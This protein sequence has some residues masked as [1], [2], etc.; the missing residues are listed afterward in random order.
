[1]PVPSW[2]MD[3][4][5]HSRSERICTNSLGLP[6]TQPQACVMNGPLLGISVS[7]GTAWPLKGCESKPSL[8]PA[9]CP[10]PLFLKSPR[11]RG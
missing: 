4:D 2:V 1:M 10:D 9:F 3:P 5:G 6:W 11:T 8:V 7:P